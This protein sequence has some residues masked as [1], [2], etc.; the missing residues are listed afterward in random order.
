[1]AHVRKTQELVT[2]IDYKVQQMCEAA[3][4]P[5]QQQNLML[6]T[7]EYDAL[8]EDVLTEMWSAAPQLR[9]QLPS[10]WC[11]TPTRIDVD[12][13]DDHGKRI[14]FTRVDSTD[15]DPL[16]CPPKVNSS[17]APDHKIKYRNL[18]PDV[19]TWMEDNKQRAAKCAE[20]ESQFNT[21]RQQLAAFMSQ[22]KSLNTAL[23]EMP[24]IELYVPE[25][26]MERYR[27]K[28]APRVKPE[29][30]TN[31]EELNIDR[32]SLAAAAIAHR[33]SQSNA[34]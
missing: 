1:M 21:V 25:R 9:N 2:A 34:A 33:M 32:D 11:V 8:R 30:P 5:H 19:V 24:E 17:Y 28:A 22:H 23:E 3:Q 31:V 4:E 27:A 14:K 18:S 13:Q 12:I 26:F 6:G 20:I 10:D 16:V 29:A 7:A 15:Q